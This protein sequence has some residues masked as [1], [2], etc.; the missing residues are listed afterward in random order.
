MLLNRIVAAI[1]LVV[2]LVDSRT[3]VANEPVSAFE[4]ASIARE[5]YVFAYPIVL[6]KVT[7]DVAKNCE[8]PQGLRAPVNQFGH[9]REFPD[10]SF[11]VVVR[12]NSDTLY[13]ALSFNV[14]AEPVVVHIPDSK[15]RYYL[16]PMLDAWTEVF[17]TPGTRTTGNGAITFAIT[18][19]DWKGTLP[20]GLKEYRSP[21]GEGLMLVRA[22]TNGKADYREVHEFQ[23]GMSCVPL[24]SFGK[25]YALPKGTYRPEQDMSPP[26]EQIAS[27]SAERFFEIFV[28]AMKENPPH[29]EDEEIISR[30]ARIGIVPGQNF[31]FAH[32]PQEIQ[33]ALNAAPIVMFQIKAS[34][35]LSGTAANGWKTKLSSIGVY[36]TDYMQRAG[37][38]F[39]ALGANIPADAV[40]PTAI[41]D[42]KGKQFDSRRSYLLHF[43]K[44][45]LPPVRAF[46]SLT[47]YNDEQRFAENPVNRYSISPQTGLRFNED[48]SLDVYIQRHSPGTD[49][50]MNWLPTPESGNFT[51]NLRLYWPEDEVLIGDWSPPP[52]QRIDGQ[53]IPRKLSQQ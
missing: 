31:K 29:P 16:A 41:L 6:M 12:P 24:S 33:G 44:D 50:E 10:P 15:G 22:Q 18:G 38:S 9:A 1:L 27:F 43:K 52:V 25:P 17:A 45:E 2:L 5:A 13:S 47:M 21:T 36:G 20:E 11:K 3:G 35:L 8:I 53:P 19:P 34:W 23:D 37:T 49:K 28:E 32:A 7:K 42:S 39:A 26:P 30:L 14:C 51:M 46:W 4:A 40:Y 48:G